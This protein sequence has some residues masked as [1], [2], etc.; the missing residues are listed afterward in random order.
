MFFNLFLK[1]SGSN[2]KTGNNIGSE[3]VKSIIKVLESNRTLT[4]LNLFG[5][6]E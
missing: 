1:I 6:E 5:E 4:E 2:K 3:G